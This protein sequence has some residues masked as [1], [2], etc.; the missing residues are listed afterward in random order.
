[1]KTITIPIMRFDIPTERKMHIWLEDY[2]ADNRA[3]WN[4]KVETI[5]FKD[6]DDA[7]AFKLKFGI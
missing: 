3:V 4:D 2:I 1:M 6:D 5:T 7:I